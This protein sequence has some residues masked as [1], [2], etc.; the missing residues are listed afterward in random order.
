MNFRARLFI[1][2]LF[3]AGCAPVVRAEFFLPAAIT[4][5]RVFVTAGVASLDEAVELRWTYADQALEAGMFTGVKVFRLRNGDEMAYRIEPL[6]LLEDV[7]SSENFRVHGLTNGS[8]VIFV[9]RAYDETGRDVDEIVLFGF[10]GSKGRDL[11]PKIEN[12]Y[13]SAGPYGISVFWDRL[14]QANISGYEVSRRREDETEYAVIGRVEKV[15]MVSGR[16]TGASSRME[17]PEVQPGMFRDRLALPGLEYVYQVRAMDADGRTGP[18]VE[19]HP[20]SLVDD[21][22][23]GPDEILLLARKGSTDSL[24]VARHYAERRGVP[25]ENILELSLPPIEQGLKPQIMDSIRKHLLTNNLAGKIRVM[26]PCYGIQLRYGNR[27]LDSMLMD[28]F[29]RFTWGRVMGTPSPSFG[30]NMHHDPSLGTYLVSRLD[31]PTQEIAKALVDKAMDAEKIVTPHS[32]SAFFTSSAFGKEGMVVAK[33]HGVQARVEDRNF[34]ISNNLS[35]ETMWMFADGHDYRAIRTSPWPPGSVAGFLKSNTLARMRDSKDK[36]WVPG[37]LE[38]G[39]TATYGAVVEPYVQGYTR[40]DILLD[41]FWSGRYT[42]A[43]AFAMATPTV[44]WA[45][46]AVGDPLYKLKVQ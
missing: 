45:M 26:V 34:A 44:R 13:V 33:R 28:P 22:S 20:V 19:T 24:D 32:G 5:G 46:S 39:V 17:L 37:L 42:F 23:P 40:G 35:D 30:Q 36:Y 16:A 15:V 29:G 43:E 38:E 31:G 8:R 14:P 6:A 12:M 11:P 21:R 9:V 10:P 1:L 4:P 18:A 25:K 7:G 27:A 2:L 41:R 3:L